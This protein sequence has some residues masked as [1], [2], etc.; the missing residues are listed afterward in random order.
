MMMMMM[1]MM[2][3][4]MMVMKVI[5]SQRIKKANSIKPSTWSTRFM[6]GRCEGCSIKLS[7]ASALSSAL[8]FSE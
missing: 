6:A 7:S 5:E 2:M 3:M 8:P 1:M 4:V